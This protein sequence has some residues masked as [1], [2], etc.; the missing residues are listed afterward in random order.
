MMKEDEFVSFFDE[1]AHW[2]SDNWRPVAGGLGAVV[3][4]VLVWWG[5]SAW[6]GSRGEDASFLLH[7]AEKAL[8]GDGTTP[9]SFDAAEPLLKEVVDRYGRTQQA[10][11]A[12]LYLARIS[13]GRGETDA[14]REA[15]RKL[16]DQHP[17]TAI[18]SAATLDLLHLRIAAG[19]GATV[20]GELQSMVSATNPPLPR[21]AAL[22]ELGML[23]V[24]EERSAEAKDPFEQLVKDFPE[25]PYRFAAQQ[26]LSELG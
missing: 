8:E 1:V 7:R 10:D 14:A 24:R 20:A 2:F 23:L 13:L 19:E 5:A 15:L 21:D 17:G 16:A 6:S 3:L 18:G 9:G 26:K 11:V 22:Y 12:R 25:S 4:V